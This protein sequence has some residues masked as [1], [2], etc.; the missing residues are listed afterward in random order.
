MDVC[1]PYSNLEKDDDLILEDR[2]KDLYLNYSLCEKG[3]TYNNISL[4]NMTV[5]C[6][7][8]IKE[9][10]TTIT[11][12]INLDKIK[13]ETTSNFDIIKCYDI[14]LKFKLKK[15]NI[16]FWIFSILIISH[17]PLLFH[18][19]Y[20]GV[21]P[22]YNFV[23]NEMIKYGYLNNNNN[24]VDNNGKKIQKKNKKKKFG[25]KKRRTQN[26]DNN[27]PPIKNKNNNNKE[28]NPIIKNYIFIKNNSIKGSF[29]KSKSRKIKNKL[30]K[31]VNSKNNNDSKLKIKNKRMKKKIINNSKDDNSNYIMIKKNK[32]LALH[33]IKTENPEDK[34]KQNIK[35]IIDF[36][37]ITIN[38]NKINKDDYYPKNSYRILNIY[39]FEEAIKY[40][41]RATCEIFFIYLISKQAIFH[42]FFFKSPLLLFSL[43]LC[44]LFF[45]F[46]CDLAL[47]ALFYFND[48]I[49]KKYHF[50]KGLFL[51]TFNNNITVILLSTFIGFILLTLFIK[52]SN[53]TF[54]MREIFRNEEE[55]IKKNKNYKVTNKRK[56]EIKNEIDKIF[57]N[58]K[59]K[60]IIFILIELLFMV[61]F[62][63]FVIIFCHVYPSTQTSWLLDSFLSMISRLI[64]D[65]LICFG[66]AKLYRIAVE[67]GIKCLYKFTLF[68]YGF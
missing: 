20:T 40:D 6:D 14:I 67:S 54:A 45:I 12:E 59:I 16:G 57:K 43:R 19:C 62:W 23:I 68:L 58:Y 24:I 2:I 61:F 3:C 37:L 65:A 8:K 9:N 46:S 17:F 15:T 36:P 22:V 30:N 50:T 44:L 21:Q 13:Y 39:S 42:A 26:N 32:N 55:K 41:H 7:C 60:I 31:N 1:K 48:N 5:L 56:I 53:S 34:N 51:F 18:Y 29:N 47:N 4:E 49:S 52:L 10:F 35:K 63:Y 25:K 28:K 33:N 64:I 11:S 38:L 27:N 66:L